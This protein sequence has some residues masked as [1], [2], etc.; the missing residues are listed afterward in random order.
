M[1]GDHEHRAGVAPICRGMSASAA[2]SFAYGARDGSSMY[3]QGPP[4]WEMK[5]TGSR[6]GSFAAQCT[7]ASRGRETR[8][9]SMQ[10]HCARCV[11][12]WSSLGC[13]AQRRRRGRDRTIYFD[14]TSAAAELSRPATSSRALRSA[15]ITRSSE[16]RLGTRA[17]I[18]LRDK[19][20]IVLILLEADAP[21]I[22]DDLNAEGFMLRRIAM[23]RR[24]AIRHHQR[25]RRRRD[26]RRP[27]TRRA[28][29]HARRRRRGRHRRAIPTC[30]C[31]APSSTSRSTCAARATRT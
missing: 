5:Y 25:R 10:R 20:V 19:R 26:V 2:S 1:R 6:C 23:A 3:D 18:T 11:A 13:A 27:R 14:P 29:P 22:R 12:R 16:A 24:H 21:R 8:G 31:A 17:H 28:D 30:P 7:L 4:P 9:D 15:R